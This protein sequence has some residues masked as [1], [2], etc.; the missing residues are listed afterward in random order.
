VFR[1]RL[2]SADAELEHFAAEYQRHSGSPI[3]IGFLR[4]AKVRAFYAANG[5]LL[6]GYAA[7]QRTPLRYSEMI[8]AGM[9]CQS[10][11]LRQVFEGKVLEI[12]VNWSDREQL[13]LSGRIMMYGWML[14]DIVA[15]GTR[16]VVAGSFKEGLSRI[17]RMWL[18]DV[19]YAGQST[20]RGRPEMLWIYAGR[21]W[22]IAVRY[23]VSIAYFTQ[24]ALRAS[25]RSCNT[26]RS[27][28]QGGEQRQ[29]IEDI[30]LGSTILLD[31]SP[32]ELG[33]SERRD[34]QDINHF[35][36]ETH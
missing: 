5:K 1:S 13:R 30:P 19:L 20:Y 25:F 33:H 10:N 23:L 36:G 2:I 12:N 16:Y 18:P 17:H 31:M 22:S 6:G 21:P 27:S 34:L 11:A 3:D 32:R 9:L 14:K 26:T 29:G 4:R 28:I 7:N 35:A 24:R 8:P 15:S